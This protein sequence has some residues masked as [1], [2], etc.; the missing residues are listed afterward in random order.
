[1]SQTSNGGRSKRRAES[2]DGGPDTSGE[3]HDRRETRASKAQR[4]SSSASPVTG[5]T[6]LSRATFT[7]GS[8]NRYKEWLRLVTPAG[9]QSYANFVGSRVE[10]DFGAGN[11]AVGHVQSITQGLR[12]SETRT[13]ASDANFPTE[14]RPFTIVWIDDNTDSAVSFADLQK[15]LVS[16]N[17]T[18][19]RPSGS[20]PSSS[21]PSGGAAMRQPPP[22]PGPPPPAPTSPLNIFTGL[23]S[24][25][26]DIVDILTRNG[27]FAFFEQLHDN[28][29]FFK[30]LDYRINRISCT[31]HVLERYADCHKLILT[32]TVRFPKQS[33]ARRLLA[34]ITRSLPSL[35]LPASRRGRPQQAMKN[36]T[37]FL[38]GDWQALWQQALLLAKKE[39]SR[40][41]RS[42]S[43]W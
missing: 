20:G 38:Q 10:Q 21:R 16:S 3:S 17:T 5:S 33:L 31:G 40:S 36:C 34:L 14:S 13:P 2:L 24:S 27:S 26:G 18:A 39:Y 7:G 25:A 4:T 23:P 29:E 19:A 15:M 6:V 32:L 8:T 37:R 30:L 1:M 43:S 12:P 9:A 35:L 28:D 41:G 22:P 42:M 11:V